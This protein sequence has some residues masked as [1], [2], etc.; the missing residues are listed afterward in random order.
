[1]SS[2]S[3]AERIEQVPELVVQAEAR[4]GDHDFSG[5]IAL[6]EPAFRAGIDSLDLSSALMQAYEG[7][8]DTARQEAL[9]AVV[10]QKSPSRRSS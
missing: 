5:A 4:L 10:L 7:A 8:G 9:M 6:L 1:M 2:T 3:F